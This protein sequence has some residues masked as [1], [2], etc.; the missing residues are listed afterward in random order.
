MAIVVFGLF[1]AVAFGVCE[2]VAF[3]MGEKL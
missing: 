2:F 3:L 1:L